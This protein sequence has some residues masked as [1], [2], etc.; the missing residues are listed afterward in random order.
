MA[1]GNDLSIQLTFRKVRIFTVPEMSFKSVL[2]FNK[3]LM[4]P[5][6]GNKN[7]NERESHLVSSQFRN[8]NDHSVVRSSE[9]IVC[10]CTLELVCGSVTV[11]KY[12]S[13]GL[14]RTSA[15]GF[16]EIVE[17]VREPKDSRWSCCRYNDGRV[18]TRIQTT[19][20]FIR[21]LG[22]PRHWKKDDPSEWVNASFW[23]K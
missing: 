22:D 5:N 18:F 19:R 2:I 15:T 7:W 6:V 14:E 9:R 16:T 1:C 4:Q 13:W 20:Y 12:C 11:H 10:Y 23:L 3:D 17:L 8:S 21:C